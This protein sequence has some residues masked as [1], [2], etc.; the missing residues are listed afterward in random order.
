MRSPFVFHWLCLPDFKV[1]QI[2]GQPEQERMAESS[3]VYMYRHLYGEKTE[4]IE[5]IFNR[6][7]QTEAE[8]KKVRD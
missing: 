3:V 2:V 5:E 8:M 6:Y 1:F 4:Y 7:N